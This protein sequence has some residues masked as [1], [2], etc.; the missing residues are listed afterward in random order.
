MGRLP[1]CIALISVWC[2]QDVR[3]VL[4]PREGPTRDV[5]RLDGVWAFKLSP[6]NDPDRGFV[7]GWYKHAWSKMGLSYEPMPVPASY[8]DIGQADELRN[9]VGWAWYQRSFHVPTSWKAKR[10]VLYFGSVHYNTAVFLNGHLAT[11][12]TVG[13]LPFEV[14]V[15]NF[16]DNSSSLN[17]ITVAVN[18]TLTL[19]TIPQGTLTLKINNT[20]YPPFYYTNT[21][22]FDFFNYA[23]IHRGVFLYE[24]EDNYVSDVYVNTLKAD[25]NESLINYTVT[26][27]GASSSRL[28]CQVSVRDRQDEEVAT[29]HGCLGQFYITK[30]KLWWTHTLSNEPGYQYTLV[31]SVLNGTKLIDSYPVKFGIRTVGIVGTRF[32]LNGKDFY[33]T[34][35]GKHEDSDIRG[36]GLDNALN[37]KDMNMVKWLGANSFRTSHYPYS[38]ELMDLADEMGIA[39]IDET[40]AVGLMHFSGNVLKLHKHILT[41]LIS[42]DKNRPSVFMW[43]VANEPQ[44]NQAESADY[45][46]EVVLHA[47]SLDR[48]RPVTAA[49]S[50]DPSVD[51]IGQFM[52]VIM[53]NKYAS[54]YSDAG[55]LQ[56]IYSQVINTY[57]SWYNLHKKPVMI[58][59]YGADTVPGLHASPAWMFSEDYQS[60]LLIK[61]HRAFDYLRTQGWF[62]GEH[63]WNFADFMTAQGLTRV[64]GNR[65]GVLTR[66]REPKAA[67]RILRCRY[68]TLGGIATT[69]DSFYCPAPFAGQ[70][71]CSDDATA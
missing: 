55:V 32:M 50:V 60:E 45:F 52:D 47:K 30:A 22:N 35:F 34:G 6:I 9:H 2:A 40:P 62:I 10:V 67:A 13:H 33:F 66:Q 70:N 8:N 18:N 44:S 20:N 48:A 58:S 38:E 61:H 42:R 28:I 21:G 29:A 65:K 31:V 57:T 49:L 16:L 11:E 4:Y 41:E 51:H 12:H 5:R 43:S 1:V 64:I 39:V 17:V 15:N 71:D 14:E 19:N 25:E 27:A 37:V 56:V 7:D 53:F 69:D 54:W 24:T 3:S 46:K 68:F 23:G 26:L 59:E 36:K 63:V